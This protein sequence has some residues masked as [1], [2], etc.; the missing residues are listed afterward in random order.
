MSLEVAVSSL[1]VSVWRHVR[2]F[3]NPNSCQ[4]RCFFR[5]VVRL[6]IDSASV[7]KGVRIMQTINDNTDVQ[8]KAVQQSEYK[9]EQKPEH[10]FIGIDVSKLTLDVDAYP[11]PTPRSFP[12]DDVGRAELVRWLHQLQ[13][14]LIVVEATGGLQTPMVATLVADGLQVAVVNPRQTRDFARALGILAKTDRVDARMLARFAQAIRPEARPQPAPETVALAGV[15][16]RRQQ[17]VEMLTAEN[18]RLLMAHPL[19]AK[20]IKQHITWLQK[21][22]AASDADL[23]NMIRKSPVWQH[24]AALLESVPGVGR[25]TATAM[26]AQLPELG[27]LS[28]KQIA[29]LVGVCPYSRDSGAMRGRRTIWGGRASLRAVLYMAALVGSRYNPVLKAF[30]QKLV[31]AG[32]PKK[33]ALVACMRKLLTILNAIVKHDRSWKF[34][35]VVATK[36]A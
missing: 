4:E 32:K 2:F 10:I 31:K 6:I 23:D 1:W 12:N 17:L 36:P 30:Y 24:K 26:L 8:T 29:G 28:N 13:P 33:V 34:D 21:R 3:F 22:L 18:N 19:V 11:N 16:A 9:P 14:T 27:M 7:R 5:F 20:T 25:V 15:L 35:E